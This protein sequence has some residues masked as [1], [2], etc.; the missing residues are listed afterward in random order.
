MKVTVLED[1]DSKIGDLCTA[2]GDVRPML[3]NIADKINQVPS[4]GAVQNTTEQQGVNVV[5][6]LDTVEEGQYFDENEEGTEQFEED[7]IKDP[8]N[9][10][11]LVGGQAEDMVPLMGPGIDLPEFDPWLT[12]QQE[13][14]AMDETKVSVIGVHIAA[15]DEDLGPAVTESDESFGT[16]L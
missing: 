8:N 5:E 9:N 14:E 13:P 10:D 16:C 15:V 2:W 12:T 6:Q 7:E 1:Y 3:Q 11:P 4:H